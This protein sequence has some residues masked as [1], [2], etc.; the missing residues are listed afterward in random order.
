MSNKSS[1][2]V[3]FSSI[4]LVRRVRKISTILISIGCS[5]TRRRRRTTNWT[6]REEENICKNLSSWLN[7]A[8]ERRWRERERE[9]DF[10]QWHHALNGEQ[11]DM[12]ESETLQITWAFGFSR[13]FSSG[14]SR[15]A[16][17]TFKRSVEEKNKALLIYLSIHISRDDIK[18]YRF[19]W[20]NILFR[21]DHRRYTP[22]LTCQFAIA[23]LIQER[24][25]GQ[26]SQ[27]TPQSLVDVKLSV[28]C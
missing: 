8:N 16:S 12:N 18:R 11:V 2:F 23:M 22:L 24:E 13:S 20:V 10:D 27:V 19:I 7:Y 28:W 3:I 5:T 26:L 17:V 25:T 6:G 9:G 4:R 14:W 1:L 15:W 21:D